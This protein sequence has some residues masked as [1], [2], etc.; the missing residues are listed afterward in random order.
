MTYHDWKSIESHIRRTLEQDQAHSLLTESFLRNARTVYEGGSGLITETAIRPV[1][2]LPD[3]E[4]LPRLGGAASAD[5]MRETVMIKLNGGLGTSMGLERAKSLLP[6]K[7][8]LSFL[9]IIAR[10]VLHLRGQ[11]GIDLPLLFMTSYNTDRDT[12]QA[13]AGYAALSDGQRGLPLTFLQHRV[14]K[15]LADNLLPAVSNKEPAL[16]WCPPGHGDIYTALV[17]S[18][19]LD[20]LVAGKFRYA[21]LSNSDNLG[22]VIDPAIPA[23]M[24]QRNIPFL[25]EVADRTEA[26]R[27][28]GH[29]AVSADSGQLLLRE[30]AQCPPDAQE[31]FQ[32]IH[33]Y[34]YFNTNNLWIDLQALRELLST[35]GATP[36]LAL[37]VNRK[38]LDPRDDTSPAVLQLETAMGSAVA[39]FK[40][41][42]ALRVPRTRFAPVKTTDD[43]L[44]LWSDAYELTSEM[45]IQLHPLRR[46]MGPPIIKLDPKYYRKIDG[47]AARFPAG[48]PSLLRCRSLTVE[49]DHTIPA[50]MVFEGDAIYPPPR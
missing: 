31:A 21:F 37:M 6:V 45:H 43:L 23:M 4:A 28:G 41:A 35:T 15:L 44:G 32:D 7:N 1:A 2:S 38:T 19:L 36:Q 26:D 12:L 27:K 24:K 14:P 17:T 30:S 50:D 3:Y 29:L 8:G 9:D 22:A 13:L 10:Q 40:H 33:R 20:K 16:A 25:L 47:F 34:R 11:Y 5:V 48:A 49:G 39:S 42:A 46:E 18:G